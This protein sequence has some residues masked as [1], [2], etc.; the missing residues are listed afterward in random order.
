MSTK[1]E[2]IN[3]IKILGPWFHNVQVMDDVFTRVINPSPGPQPLTHPFQRWQALEPHLPESMVGLNVLDVGSA[4]GFFSVEF[5]KRGANVLA[6]DFWKQM[7]DRIDFLA[8]V[9]DLPIS[10]LVSS[11]EDMKLDEDFDMIFN[12]GLLYHSKHPLLLLENL[13]TISH[14]VMYLETT[15]TKGDE[16]LLYFKPPQEAVH[17]IP[18]WFPTR[19]CVIDMLKFVG[20]S[21]IEIFEYAT[22]DRILLR[23]EK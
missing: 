11:A 2:L 14:Q 8:D 10:T 6:T 5:A 22:P 17:H 19:S 13:Y 12:L 15:I 18:K 20:Y 1:E 3:K 9:M 21:K 23:A 4:D 7:I 16:P